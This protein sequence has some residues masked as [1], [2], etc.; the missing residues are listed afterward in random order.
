M[1]RSYERAFSYEK[2]EKRWKLGRSAEGMARFKKSRSTV[3]RDEITIIM[4]ELERVADLNVH[5]SSTAILAPEVVDMLCE[6]SI[7]TF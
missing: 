5:R 6:T 4:Y 2:K 7:K 3:L 1:K